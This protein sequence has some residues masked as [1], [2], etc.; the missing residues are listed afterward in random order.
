M[1]QEE[2]AQHRHPELKCATFSSLRDSGDGCCFGIFSLS[3]LSWKSLSLTGLLLERTEL[4]LKSNFGANGNRSVRVV[5]MRFFGISFPFQGMGVG[6]IKTFCISSFSKQ[7]GSCR[8]LQLS[9][10]PRRLLPGGLRISPRNGASQTHTF[11]S[12]S[13]S[14]SEIKIKQIPDAEQDNRAPY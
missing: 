5:M 11:G 14:H 8:R 10:A 1:L 13:F 7:D 6:E 4:Y 9:P 2:R 3:Q 12:L